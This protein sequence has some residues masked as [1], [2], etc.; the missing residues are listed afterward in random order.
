MAAE[1]EGRMLR[2]AKGGDSA[3]KGGVK[4]FKMGNLRAFLRK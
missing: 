3:L 4:A 2:D 1:G